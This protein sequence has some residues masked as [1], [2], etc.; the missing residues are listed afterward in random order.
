[1]KNHKSGKRQYRIRIF[2][3]F[4]QLEIIES[5]KWGRKRLLHYKDYLFKHSFTSQITG[6][7]TL[8]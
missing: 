7:K 8:Y 1:M 5:N 2:I 3:Q 4:D 6:T